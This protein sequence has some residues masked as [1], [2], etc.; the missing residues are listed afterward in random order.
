MN[1]TNTAGLSPSTRRSEETGCS[2]PTP[3]G[4]FMLRR[5]VI[6]IWHTVTNNGTGGA[7]TLEYIADFHYEKELKKKAA[8]PEMKS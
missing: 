5:P 6:R 1:G 4:S 2:P 3:S 8:F 7:Q